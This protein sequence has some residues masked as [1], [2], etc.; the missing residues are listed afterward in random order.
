M[1]G[2]LLHHIEKIQQTAVNRWGKILPVQNPT[3]IGVWG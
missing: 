3:K 1:Y 2:K